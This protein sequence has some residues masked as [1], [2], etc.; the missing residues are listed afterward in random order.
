MSTD[1]SKRPPSFV[2]DEAR[3]LKLFDNPSV[4]T[5]FA[6]IDVLRE[7]EGEH[8]LEVAELKNQLTDARQRATELE[9]ELNALR[10]QR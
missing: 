4:E 7:R 3:V 6:A 8:L 1:T 5:L 9:T 2:V 10:A